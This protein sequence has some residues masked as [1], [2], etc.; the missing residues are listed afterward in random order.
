MEETP[1]SK[2]T[3]ALINE[4]SPY[5][6][7]HAHNPVN[8]YPWC[9]EALD[10]ALTEDKPII[11][12]I[13]YSACHWCHV[14]AHESFAD[15]TTAALMNEHF[16]CIKVDREERPDIDQVYMTFVQ[17]TTG[18][19]G[20]PLNVFLTPAQEPFFGGTYF[21]PTDRYGKPSWRNVLTEV[22]R[23]Y[24]QDKSNLAQYV[25]RV[26]D[27]FK[28][29]QNKRYAS[30][31]LDVSVFADAEAHVA[32]LY[33][34]LYGGFGHAPKFP[35]VPVLSFLLRR[36]QRSGN[37]RLLDMVTHTLRQMARG[38]IY[39]QLAGGFSRYSVDERWLVPHF[40]KMLYDNAQLAT[41]YLDT[42]LV[43]R[44]DFFMNILRETLSFVASELRSEQGGFYSSLDADSEGDEGTYYLWDRDEIERI[45]GEHSALFAEYYDVAAKGNF[46]G[47]NILH[48]QTEISAVAARFGFNETEV[49]QILTSCRQKLYQVRSR[50]VRPETDRK[51]LTSWNALMISAFA[52]ACKVLQTEE[53]KNIIV[54]G[55]DFI[56]TNLVK[57]GRLQRSYSNGRAH[58]YPAFLDDYAFLI[59][60]LWHAYEAVF[61]IRYLEWAEELLNHVNAHFWD[62]KSPGYFYTSTEHPPLI[63]RLKDDF[64][65]STPAATAIMIQNNLRFYSLTRKSLLRQRSEWMLQSFNREMRSNPYSCSSYLQALDYFLYQPV[66]IVL[67]VPDKAPTRDFYHKIYNRF[68]PARVVFQLSPDRNSALYHSILFQG[69]NPVGRDTAVYV[70]KNSTCAAPVVTPEELEILLDKS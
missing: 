39:D 47:K 31:N 50:R 49:R 6:L 70:C 64:D 46:A 19:G 3:N 65:Q 4:T 53:Y 62:D 34:P 9:K 45:L 12:S 36:Y 1:E 40:E 48:I 38:G 57:D 15:E 33:D 13:G 56:R 28:H 59:D 17:M 18:S 30:D 23:F 26:R 29:N 61:D 60:A 58:N 7:Q 20:W 27:T 54:A 43:T 35:S 66:E 10:R 52:Q 32:S 69:K 8:W 37:P 63:A 55:I 11:L 21:P 42:Y 2:Y 16:I 24:R 41:L 22:S 25:D 51:I 5:L 68:Q 67:A 14:M 44:D